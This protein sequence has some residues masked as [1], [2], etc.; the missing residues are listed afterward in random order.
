M[1]EP[2]GTMNSIYRSILA[3][4]LL[5]GAA[6]PG[7]AIV[8]ATW[9]R[10]EIVVVQGTDGAMGPDGVNPG[11]SGS[12]GGDGEPVTASA[13]S[14]FSL[15]KATATAGNGGAGGNADYNGSGDSGNGGGGGKAIAAAATTVVVGPAE[16]DGDFF[17]AMVVQVEFRE[18]AE[19]GVLEATPPQR[20]R[21]RVPA[22]VPSRATR[23]RGP[24]REATHAA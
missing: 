14:T 21:R 12:P 4:W 1:G 15:N 19:T 24:A 9:T 6:L 18:A 2:G 13:G 3:R 17:G 22:V 8:G 7:F 16:A 23:L 11:D 20:A 5:T 10:A